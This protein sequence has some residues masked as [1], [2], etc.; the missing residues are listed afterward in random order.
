MSITL[1]ILFG[2]WLFFGMD[3]ESF[4]PLYSNHA[5]SLQMGGIP[6]M[7]LA[8]LALCVL[9][10][11]HRPLAI[12]NAKLARNEKI[13]ADSA[14]FNGWYEK[15]K[16]DDFI[17]EF[18]GPALEKN[19]K[20]EDIRLLLKEFSAAHP[21][22]YDAFYSFCKSCLKN[23]EKAGKQTG[24]EEQIRQKPEENCA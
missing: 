22:S 17:R 3:A 20:E 15:Q 4:H 19:F 24:K 16:D 9:I 10:F 1:I 5:K 12:K 21:F 23:P 18:A 2:G 6:L 7:L 13:T 8:S 14:I 11:H